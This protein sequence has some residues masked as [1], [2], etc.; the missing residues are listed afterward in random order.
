MQIAV[1]NDLHEKG[2]NNHQHLH[3][4]ANLRFR[5]LENLAEYQNNS[6]NGRQRIDESKG[7]DTD[8]LNTV[9]GG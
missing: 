4:Q 6:D 9:L 3:N 8:G 1:A 2:H 7:Y 5:N